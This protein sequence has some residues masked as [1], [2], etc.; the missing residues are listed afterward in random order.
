[1][2]PKRRTGYDS[3]MSTSLTEAPTALSIWHAD[4]FTDRPFAGN[5]AAVCVLPRFG[6]DVWMQR[7]ATEMALSETA[8]LVR[9]EDE[10]PDEARFDLRWFTPAAEVDLCGHATLA[11]AHVLWES[12][13][14]PAGKPIRFHTLSGEL[15]AEPTG[16]C[17]AVARGET[18]GGWI[19][20]DFPAEVAKP[21]DEEPSEKVAEAVGVAPERVRQVLANRLDL[22]VEVENE[23]TVRGLEPDLARITALSCRGV[24]VTAAATETEGVDFVSRYFAPQFGVPEDPVTGSAHCALAPF[25]IERLG[26]ERLVGYQV[27]AR[28]GW[29]RVRLADG[30]RRVKLAG[31][32][33]TVLRGELAPLAAETG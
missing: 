28:G 5:P 29:V 24:I 16:G 20:L 10:G 21:W 30:G 26:H 31:Q 15:S 33:V 22:L 8:F 27:S 11:S 1:M 3:S 18:G 23:A 19:E 32:A 4:A 14:A 17:G 7:V 2:A 12:G 13:Q 25:W 9:R 6:S